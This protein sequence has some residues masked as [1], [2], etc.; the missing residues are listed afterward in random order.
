MN[1]LDAK[2]KKIIY[3]LD[4]NARQSYSRIGKKVGLKKT[5]V[6]YR[7]NKL[8]KKGVIRNFYTL[9][10]SYKLGYS[11]FRMYI[12]FQYLTPQIEKEIC[13]HFSNYRSIWWTI[14]AEGRF[15]LAVI[16]WVKSLADFYNFWDETL[17]KYRDYFRIQQFSMYIQSYN[18]LHEYL[19][20]ETTINKR[21][22]YFIAGGN[23]NKN[24]SDIDMNIL[25]L[26]SKNARIPLRTI[27]EQTYLPYHIINKHIKQLLEKRIIQGF[28]VDIDI[29]KLGFEL[30]KADIFLKEYQDRN[31]I[32]NYIRTNPYL[33]RIDKSIGISDL[34]LEF[35]VKNQNHFQD[36]MEDL[37]E[38][39]QCSI[40]N[41]KYL[42]ASKIHQM[43]LLPTIE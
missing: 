32:I 35:H 8:L 14:S 10:D 4:K 27:A 28:R 19:L 15:D 17:L 7:V 23:Q 29:E 39:F 30:Y 36:I 21:K 1:F 43:K 13:Q 18:F 11:S 20:S 33:I 40:R 3:L 38:K 41:Y 25:Q 22:M 12:G 6:A 42:S 16:I 26:L 5:V 34:E 37:N 24:I 9:V 31:K 2:D